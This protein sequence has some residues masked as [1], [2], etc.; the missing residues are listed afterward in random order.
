VNIVLDTDVLIKLAKTSAKETVASNFRAF[1]PPGG[2]EGER[3]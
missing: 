1:V 2:A 3:G